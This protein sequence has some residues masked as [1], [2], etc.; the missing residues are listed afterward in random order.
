MPAPDAATPAP[1]PPAAH[2]KAARWP[3]TAWQTGVGVAI[4]LAALWLAWGT[5]QIPA[6]VVPDAAGT[7]WLPGLCAGALLVCGLCLVWEARHGGWRHAAPLSGQTDWQVMPWVWVSAGILLSALLLAHSG[8]IVAAA[9]CYVL[10]LQGLRRAA[11]PA[12]RLQARRLAC[13]SLVGLG[14]AG[15]VYVLFTQVLGIALPAGWL[16]WR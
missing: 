11:D 10:A 16:A 3:S 6:P 14:I 1:P 7:R 9:L 5:W 2:A 12:L 4:A 13:D 15:A 8:F